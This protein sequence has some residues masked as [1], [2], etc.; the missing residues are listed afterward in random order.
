MKKYVLIVSN[1]QNSPTDSSYRNLID[2]IQSHQECRIYHALPPHVLIFDF[3]GNALQ[4]YSELKP[5][6]AKEDDSL[7]LQMEPDFIGNAANVERIKELNQFFNVPPVKP[8]HAFA[9]AYVCEATHAGR[10]CAA[11]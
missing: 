4:A 7:L 1:S 2:K 8:D 9:P 3:E 11:H 6:V 5:C 10:E